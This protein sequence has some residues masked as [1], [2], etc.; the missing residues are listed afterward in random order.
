MNQLPS[1]DSSLKVSRA[2]LEKGSSCA[3][4]QLKGCLDVVE[5]PVAMMGGL[6]AANHYRFGTEME[7]L[8]TEEYLSLSE[9]VQRMEHELWNLKVKEFDITAYTKRFHK[10]VQL[11]RKWF[12]V[13]ARN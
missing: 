9:E 12:P 1:S 2:V 6:E 7:K 13:N 5:F 10:L 3:L 11:V 8:T 4:P